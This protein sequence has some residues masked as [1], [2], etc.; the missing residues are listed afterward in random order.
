MNRGIDIEIIPSPTE[1]QGSHGDNFYKYEQIFEKCCNSKSDSNMI[2]LN[3]EVCVSMH[4]GDML[5]AVQLTSSAFVRI[6]ERLE[7]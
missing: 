4:N 6:T 2:D 1:P 5:D 3:S 7:N